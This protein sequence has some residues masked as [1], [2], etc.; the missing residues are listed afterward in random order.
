MEVRT[1]EPLADDCHRPI[2][3]T[4]AFVIFR[5]EQAST[6]RR[7]AE[8]AEISAADHEPISELTIAPG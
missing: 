8:H 7:H 4:A 5:Q 1:P 6:Q 2:H 3:A